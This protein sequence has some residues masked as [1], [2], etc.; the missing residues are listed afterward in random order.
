MRSRLTGRQ[1]A[2][3]AK[4]WATEAGT[5]R[6]ASRVNRRRRAESWW[7]PALAPGGNPPVMRCTCLGVFSGMAIT[8][9]H[10]GSSAMRRQG[11]PGRTRMR[12][13]DEKDRAESYARDGFLSPIPALTR[14]EAAAAR[15]R[16]EDFENAVGGP[17]TSE[18]TDPRWR[19]R[20]HVALTWVHALARHPAILDTVQELIGPDILVY[21]STWF[22][23]EPGSA[24]IAAWH[25]DATYFG[26]R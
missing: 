5:S 9:R 26:L 8:W 7:C 6:S 2:T 17:L 1:L 23:K 21:T 14:Q 18:A 24:A 10:L 20:T 22:I 4:S 12:L 19:S 16:L 3:A 13:M 11:H 25:Q 15:R